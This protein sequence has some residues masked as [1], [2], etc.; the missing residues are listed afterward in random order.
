[1]P[2]LRKADGRGGLSLS[3][4]SRRYGRYQNELAVIAF[5]IRKA[6][7]VDLGL[8][9]P[10]AFEIVPAYA[11]LTGYILNMAHAAALRNIK[12]YFSVH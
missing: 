1:M 7:Q 3:G 4:R 12:I 11:E 6:A 5:Y 9:F 10:I 2:I 8:I